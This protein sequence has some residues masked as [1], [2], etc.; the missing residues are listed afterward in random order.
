MCRVEVHHL[1]GNQQGYRKR[2]DSGP[3]SEGSEPSGGS[4]LQL[5]IYSKVVVCT[6]RKMD[7]LAEAERFELEDSGI[8]IGGG[9]CGQSDA[10]RNGED[11]KIEEA[12]TPH[13]GLFFGLKQGSFLD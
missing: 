7:A 5:R 12:H 6:I 3:R 11:E 8:C 10:L 13:N 1:S 9:S 2:G 4:I